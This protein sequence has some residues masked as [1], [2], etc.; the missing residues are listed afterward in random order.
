M[1]RELNR[2]T[3]DSE[4]RKKGY[5]HPEENQQT[6]SPY[7]VFSEE[8]KTYKPAIRDPYANYDAY[9]QDAK[10]LNEQEKPPTS[11]PKK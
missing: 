4:L 7:H 8:E 3:L 2:D 6:F 11:L 5:V 1:N 10:P 9:L